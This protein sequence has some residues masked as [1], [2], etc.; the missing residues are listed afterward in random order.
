MIKIGYD[1]LKKDL[2]RIQ[3]FKN[4]TLDIGKSRSNKNSNYKIFLNKNQY[5]NFIENGSIKYRLTDVKKRKH[6]MIGDGIASLIQIAL[7]FIKSVTPK[8]L[9]TLGLSS[10]G[11]ITS[12]AI[13]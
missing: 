9:G 10:I 2:N 11:A 7:P 3:E 8:V 1:F 5:N 4:P 6:V 13:N 12:S